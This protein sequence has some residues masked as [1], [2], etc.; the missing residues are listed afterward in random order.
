MEIF[1]FVPAALISYKFCHYTTHPKSRI[2]YKFPKIKIKRFQLSPS[3]RLFARGRIIHM[4]H[5]FY[6]TILLGA[7]VYTSGGWLDSLF[8]KGLLVGGILQGFSLPES[9][10][11][12][13][14]I[15]DAWKNFS[16][17]TLRKPFSFPPEKVTYVNMT[18]ISS[19]AEVAKE[20]R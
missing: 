2:W 13:Y 20:T 10:K 19:R 18:S 9:R 11:L 16:R 6:C 17:D 15:E 4:H 7:S 14:G 12:V 8:T 1:S 5:W 3:I